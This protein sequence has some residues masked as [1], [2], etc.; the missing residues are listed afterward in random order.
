MNSS[1]FI[2]FPL[3]L[4]QKGLEIRF[5]EGPGRVPQ[6]AELGGVKAFA[7]AVPYVM[8]RPLK[9]DKSLGID[10]ISMRSQGT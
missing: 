10:E 4:D 3:N 9:E 2:F 5:K 1:H 8:C 7:W 6:D